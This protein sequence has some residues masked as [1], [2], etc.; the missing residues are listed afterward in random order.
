MNQ[1]SPLSAESI[2]IDYQ[3][4]VTAYASQFVLSASDEELVLDC[5]AGLLPD[6]PGS[7]PLLPV[8]TRL[9][10]S[11]ASAQ[12]LWEMLGAAMARQATRSASAHETARLEA[13][14]PTL[15]SNSSPGNAD[16]S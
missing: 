4:A 14:L 13:R 11:H 1:V 5:A 10:L 8:H 16:A 15:R 9:V 12:R 7:A 6:A 2:R 3:G